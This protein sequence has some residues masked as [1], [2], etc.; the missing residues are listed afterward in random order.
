M[1]ATLWISWLFCGVTLDLKITRALHMKVT[2]IL[3]CVTP[4]SY[5]ARRDEV[6]LLPIAQLFHWGKPPDDIFRIIH[7]KSINAH[8][9]PYSECYRWLA[10]DLLLHLGVTSAGSQMIC[11]GLLCNLCQ[12]SHEAMLLEMKRCRSHPADG[13]TAS[14][15]SEEQQVEMRRVLSRLKANMAFTGHLFFFARSSSREGHN[16]A[17]VRFL[18]R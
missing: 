8:D 17:V 2:R 10:F 13:K 16:D 6:L 18:A 9:A 4:D 11:R 3:N 5:E 12:E 1:C 15:T 14:A 7:R